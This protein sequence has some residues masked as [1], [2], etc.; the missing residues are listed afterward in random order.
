MSLLKRDT[1]NQAM[2]LAS[3]FFH[4]DLN[5]FMP[6]ERKDVLF[7]Y[8]FQGP[9]SVKH[10]IESLGAPHTEVG[11]ILVNETPSGFDY[12]VQDGDVIQV[13]PIF[14]TH[15]DNPQLCLSF[16]PGERKFILDNHLGRLANYLRMLG[17]DC[18][19]QNDYQDDY[20]AII[21]S[22]GE[23]ILLTRD[24]RLLMRNAVLYGYWVRNKTPRLQLVEVMRRYALANQIAPFRRCIRCNGILS[25]TKKEDVIDRLLPLT[26]KYFEEFRICPDC[27]QVY[28]KGSHYERMNKLIQQALTQASLADK[29]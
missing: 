11:H 4:D 17:V 26:K 5:D 13:F 25:P 2:K 27:G 28:W 16:P 20:L 23:R 14:N 19:Y 3:F 10:L 21:A 18:L 29:Y 15:G 8:S 1:I 12:L 22:N 24:R 9:Q 6:D 7:S